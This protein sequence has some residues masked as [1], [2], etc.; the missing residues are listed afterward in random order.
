MTTIYD[1]TVN[2][3]QGLPF[4]LS[5]YQGKVLLIINTATKCGFTKQ[6]EALE[7]LYKEFAN[8]NFE[9]LDFPCNQFLGQAPGT[10]EEI[11][12]FCS[13]NYGTT[14]PR[15]EKIEVNGENAS[16][17]YQWLRQSKPNDEGADAKAFVEKMLSMVSHAK[18]D[19]I[20]WNFTKFLVDASGNVVHR[21]SPTVEPEELK[22][23]IRALL[24]KK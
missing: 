2:D 14:F 24:V 22:E 6:Y 16:P 19:D 4:P 1:F 21:Y 7:A 12:E 18:K 10:S 13:L 17:L 20:H 5:N 9:I 23:D 3:Q 15:F 8:E 11:N